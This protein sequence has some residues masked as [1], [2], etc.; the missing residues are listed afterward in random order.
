MSSDRD[1][2]EVMQPKAA[3]RQLLIICVDVLVFV[4]LVCVAAQLQMMLKP[5]R[6]LGGLFMLPCI[7]YAWKRSPLGREENRNE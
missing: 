1:S 3:G 6:W 4:M 2:G 7:L 5:P